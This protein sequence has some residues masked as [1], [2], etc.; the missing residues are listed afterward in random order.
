[1]ENCI[2]EVKMWMTINMLKLNDDK[3]EMMFFARRG[4]AE[5][6]LTTTLK[7]GNA[8]ISPSKAVR[9]LGSIMDP[10]LSMEEQVNMLIRSASLQIRNIY[11]V[12]RYLTADAAKSDV[13]ALILNRLDYANS[14][15]YGITKQQIHKLQKIQN[16]AA[17]VIFRL[18]RR[19]HI[20]PRLK[21]LHWL[22]IEHRLKYKLGVLTY[23]CIRGMAPRYLRDLINIKMPARDLRSADSPTL[24]DGLTSTERKKLTKS[25]ERAFQYAAPVLWNKLPSHLQNA[26]NIQTFKRLLKTHLFVECYNL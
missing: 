25:G 6:Y 19:D 26:E 10:T 20:T 2:E 16:T 15:L 23:L 13:Q 22:K 14:L 4:R 11:K 7:I 8:T 1:M 18:N 12:R 21:D 24:D 17:R 5:Q 3:T 9:N